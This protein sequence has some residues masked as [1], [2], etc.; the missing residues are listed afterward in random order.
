MASHRETIP[1]S[2]E[3]AL[4]MLDAVGVS[5]GFYLAGGTGLAL[6]LGHRRSEDLDLFREAALTSG[7]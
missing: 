7:Y 4:A 2:V 1:P 5:T 6:H 3:K